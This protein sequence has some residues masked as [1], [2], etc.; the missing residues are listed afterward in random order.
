M[1]LVLY[2]NINCSE[3]ISERE[4]DELDKIPY[5]SDMNKLVVWMLKIYCGKGDEAL[6]ERITNLEVSQGL[7]YSWLVNAVCNCKIANSEILGVKV[8]LM[9]QKEDFEQSIVLR[10]QLYDFLM[11]RKYNALE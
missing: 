2:K 8:Y 5:K 4:L 7:V 10:E 9:L 3:Y 6:V 1:P 11:E